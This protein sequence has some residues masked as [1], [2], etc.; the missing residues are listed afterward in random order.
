MLPLRCRGCVECFC[1]CVIW[2]R[3]R[4]IHNIMGLFVSSIKHIE[5]F[6]KVCL[7]EGIVVGHWSYVVIH[8]DLVGQAQ[9]QAWNL[10]WLNVLP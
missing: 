8:N 6:C 9:G 1:Y 3:T 5:L 2:E 10:K 7:Q 4:E